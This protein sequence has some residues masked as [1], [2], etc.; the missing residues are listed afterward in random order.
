NPFDKIK[1]P[2]IA[3]NN[4]ADFEA[5]L[6]VIIVKILKMFIEKMLYNMFWD[7]L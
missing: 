6:A 1:V 2:T 3:T 7:I 4:Q 5:E